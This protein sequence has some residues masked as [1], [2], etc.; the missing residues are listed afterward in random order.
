MSEGPVPSFRAVPRTGVIYVTTEAAK[1]GYRAGRRASWCNLGQGSPRPASSRAAP[2]DARVAID[3]A[4]PGVRAGRRPVGAARGDRVA[5]QQRL[6]PRHAV[7]V[8]RRERVRLG[9]RARGAHA[10]GGEPRARQPRPLPAR[11]HG[12]RGAARHLQGRSPPSRSCSRPSAA[13]R[14]APS[15]LRREILGRG[16]SAPPRSNPCNPTGKLVEGEELARWVATARE[17]DCALLLDEFYSHYVYRAAAR[18]P[19]PGRERRALRRGRRH[20]IR[21]SSSTG[22]RRTGATR[23]G[24]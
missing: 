13:T 1:L 23:A 2:R 21:W 3:P 24:A 12:V 18:G 22:S 7:A 10:R 20:A 4:R 8:L 19:A 6:P 15:D 5:L 9:R 16:L 11:L 14:S 17:L